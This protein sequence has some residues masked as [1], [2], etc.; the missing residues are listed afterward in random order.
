MQLARR[1]PPA[2]SLLC[3]AKVHFTALSWVLGV[4]VDAALFRLAQL[5]Q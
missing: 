3:H 5:K 4:V 1:F 2:P